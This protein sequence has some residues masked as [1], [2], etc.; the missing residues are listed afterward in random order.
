MLASPCL[1]LSRSA[2]S[3][4]A[5]AVGML[6][7]GVRAG[8]VVLRAAAPSLLFYLSSMPELLLYL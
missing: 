6:L 3:L 7:G 5:A 2:L 8:W 1:R 4:R